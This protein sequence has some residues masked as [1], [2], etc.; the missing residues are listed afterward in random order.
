MDGSTA[1]PWVPTISI[2]VGVVGSPSRATAS[3]V[4]K[5]SCDP[6]SQIARKVLWHQC[7]AFVA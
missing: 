2:V 1:S 5:F 3:F 6:V 7:F 4:I